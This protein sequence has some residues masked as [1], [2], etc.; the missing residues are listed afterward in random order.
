MKRK[1][2]TAWIIYDLAA[3][4]YGLMIPSV[5]FAIYFTSFVAVDHP[6]ADGLWSLAVAIPL[7]A[8]GLLSPCLG[9]IA[10]SG[11]AR[12]LMLFAA[13]LICAAASAL[14]FFVR[15]GDIVAG[16]LL[17]IVAQLCYLLATALYNSYLPRISTAENS[18]RI[19]GLAW[20]LS[21]L[22]G[23]ACFLL[24]LPFIKAGIVAGNESYFA[25]AFLVAAGF[26]LVFGVGSL[27]AFPG[28]AKPAAR[29]ESENPYRRLWQLVSSWRHER[30]IPRF[31]LAYYLLNDAMV[32]VLYFTAIFMKSTFGLSMQEILVL[33][34]VFQ[35]VA[36]PATIFFGW[37][38]DRWNQHGA[39]Y[40]T[41]L[42]WT[43]V[44]ALMAVA[45][46]QYA[47]L[48]IAITLGL[49]LGS[50]QSLLRS[51]YSQMIPPDRSG[52]YFGFHALAGRASSALGP[53]LF[54]LVSVMAGSQRLAMASLGLFLLAGV[55]ILVSVRPESSA[56][57]KR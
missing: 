27:L 3:H 4:G 34:L 52:E 55:V 40:L 51:M 35:L 7:L 20:G 28:D 2:I 43:L 49:V 10:D 8:A 37:L 22:G 54:G 56:S 11:G 9:A 45:E 38:G 36:I 33:S 18:A 30:E 16:M 46:G 19:S 15:Q 14:L 53:L 32:T 13:T 17:F 25:N 5:G 12:R 24:C 42:I 29:T 26:L 41:L 6:Y 31:L 47:P 48:A 1:A 50:T 44:L 39:I 21:Y 57:H 23:I